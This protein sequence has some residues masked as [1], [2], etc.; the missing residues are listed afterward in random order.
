MPTDPKSN[1]S[2]NLDPASLENEIERLLSSGLENFGVRE[3][4][5]LMLSAIGQSERR[6]YL[7]QP[8]ADKG[9]GGYG[10]SLNVGSIPVDIEVPR[11]RSGNFRPRP[12]PP[13]YQ[14]GYSDE[15]QAL[16]PGLLGS[17]R[18]LNAAKNAL[19]KMGLGSCAEER[20]E[21]YTSEL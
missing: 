13:P 8:S 7:A 4:L 3:L 5:G 9:N 19:K 17:S 15:A 1:V 16:I 10:R 20:S 21:E 12:L 18:S 6:T 14:R 2:Q 11:T